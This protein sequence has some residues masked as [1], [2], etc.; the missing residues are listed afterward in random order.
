MEEVVAKEEQL[1]ED[2]GDK[3]A[4]PSI[5]SLKLVNLPKLRSFYSGNLTLECP[6]LSDLWRKNCTNMHTFSS[7]LLITPK[8]SNIWADGKTLKVGESKLTLD[9]YA[10]TC[11]KF[12]QIIQETVTAKQLSNPT[13]AAATLRVFFHD[14]MVEGCD[15]SVLI[16]S[17]SFNKAERDADI[18]ESLPGDA[19]DIV[20]RAKTALE[21]ACPG[22][23]SCADILALSTR[24]LVKMVGG[25][26]YKVRLGRKDG[27]VSQASRVEGNLARANMSMSVIIDIFKAKGFT[28]EEMVAL[29]GGGHTIG[30]SHCKEFSSRIYNHSK[31]SETDPGMNPMFAEALRKVCANYQ[32]DTAMSAFNDVMT[33]SKFDNMYFQNLFRGLGLLASDHALVTDPRTKPIVELFAKDQNAFFQA[34]AHSMEKVSV[35]GVKTGRKGEVRNRCDVFNSIKT[36]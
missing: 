8:L 13:T 21:L 1:G 10:K 9:Y 18:N 35:V 6:S 28:I 26:Y 29:T 27:L 17:N 23:V 24:N 36:D 3:L 16:S 5:C 34:F 30:F 19:F 22:I 25:P 33:P 20:I 12:E 4:F 14:C 32:K 31:T 15:A 7:R 2:S 11:P